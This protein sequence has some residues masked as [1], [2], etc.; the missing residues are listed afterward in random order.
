MDLCKGFDSFNHTLILAV[1]SAYGFSE[2]AI[3]YIDSCKAF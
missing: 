2:N 1:L 3:A